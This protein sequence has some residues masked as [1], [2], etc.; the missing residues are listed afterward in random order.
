[1]AGPR[2]RAVLAVLAAAQGQVV[3][4]ERLVEEVW[5]G[6]APASAPQT[7]QVFVSKLRKVLEPDR[8]ARA[9]A[10]V[11][12]SV[13]PGY[14]LASDAVTL[15]ADEFTALTAEGARLRAGSAPGQARD[16]LTRA[17]ALWRGPAYADVADV[18]ALRQEAARLEELRATAQEELLAARLDLPGGREAVGELEAL[19]AAHPWRER[20]REL[21]A[22]G[23]YRAGRQADA[24][25]ALR[26]A[27]RHLADELG[28]DP[29]PAL[30]R[31][32]AAILA[33]DPALDL[34][35]DLASGL[36]PDLALGLA[37]DLAPRPTPPPP[38]EPASP[39]ARP[40]GRRSALPTALSSFVGRDR[41]LAQ[42]AD[43][44]RSSRV[45]TLVGSGGAGKTRLAL[46]AARRHEGADGPW[47]VL[48]A[49]VRDPALVPAAVADALGVAASVG[50]SRTEAVAESLRERS[51]L[52][53]LDNC[54]H[55]LDAAADVVTAILET[56]PDVRVLATSRERLGVPGEALVAVAPLPVEAAP[57]GAPAPAVRL[58]LDR[59]AAV[60][61]GPWEPD[62]AELD[63]VRRVC[64]ALDGIP[65][66]LELAASRCDVLSPAQLLEHLGDRFEVLA[67]GRP[68][69]GA[70]SP[71]HHRTLEAAVEWSYAMLSPD[72]QEVFCTLSVFDGG[73]D[74]DAAAAVAGRPVLRPL[75]GLAAKSMI[76]V[77]TSAS[78]RRYGMLESLREYAARALP[79]AERATLRDRHAAWV[80][81]LAEQALPRL[82]TRDCTVWLRR[83][84]AEQSN[85]RAA[86]GHALASGD[87][88]TAARI[89][90][91]LGWAWYRTGPADEGR[92]WLGR[93]LAA[94]PGA[95]GRV[96]VRGLLALAMLSY[97]M[98]DVHGGSGHLA[99]AMSLA[100]AAR[101]PDMYA[102]ANVYAGYFQALIGNPDAGQALAEEARRTAQQTGYAWVQAE[103]YQTL[104]L[105]ARLRGEAARAQELLDE[106]AQI[107]IECGHL[108]AAASIGW[109]AAKAGLDRGDPHDT[110][111]R[112][113]PIL[114]DLY[115]EHDRTSTLVGVHTLAGALAACGRAT[116]GAVLL[117]AVAAQGRE[118]GYA[119]ALMDPV[120]CGRDIALVEAA[121][122]GTDAEAA[123][124]R[125][126]AL[127][128]D[129]MLAYALDAARDELA[130]VTA[131]R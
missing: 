42:V 78:P 14:A 54:E 111:R 115:E 8:P 75:T 125:G 23:L 44:L 26:E 121:V 126:R 86:L 18:P 77:D 97:L 79:P 98:G 73:F 96:R 1:M 128:W 131:G 106:G 119:P 22:L 82:R 112:L 114:R 108:W 41:E 91:A 129:A 37:P 93:A 107:A 80:V 53:V 20:P 117:A 39:P 81:D 15:D 68:R 6:Q 16:A 57:D 130:A 64:A 31:L 101:E 49:G 88:G 61:G 123:R 63:A 118:I 2:Q 4:A 29:G 33:Q 5:A 124:E 38:A 85:V 87:G 83:L 34:A 45:V 120:D 89:A 32:E 3:P 9:P 104:G 60:M 65:L 110:L 69:R 35:P 48:L 7:L 74:L 50:S 100:D 84:S 21:L 94:A 24:L 58:F 10:T 92:E 62:A 43:W 109:I 27:R 113:V 99:E 55:V 52:L 36:A 72:E 90:S 11:L 59:A 116:D 17:L 70:A 95:P 40:A 127:G 66:A 122:T 12:V 76:T 25:A 51:A 103:A 102:L 46:E 19:V 13:P 56:A 71:R 47:L 67:D 105:V 30:Q 28:I